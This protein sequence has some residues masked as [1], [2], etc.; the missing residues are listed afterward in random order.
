MQKTDNCGRGK[1]I[2]SRAPFYPFSIINVQYQ[3]RYH[4]MSRAVRQWR[5]FKQ[6]KRGGGGHI[7]NGLAS[8][9]DGSLALECPACPHPGRNLPQGWDDASEDKKYVRPSHC[10]TLSLLTF[11][12]WLYTCFLAVDANFR[13]KL[14]RRGI[15]DLEIG[16]GWAYFVE[17]RRYS[18][19]V[20]KYKAVETEVSLVK[21][22]TIHFAHALSGRWLRF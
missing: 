1:V 15:E 19:H 12:R 13:L 8:I 3:H 17:N 21:H 5:I 10:I 11:S 16:S 2:V 18:E 7:A 22:F 14:K 6:A 4:Q 20:S 9:T